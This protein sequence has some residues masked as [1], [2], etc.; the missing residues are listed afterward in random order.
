MGIKMKDDYEVRAIYKTSDN[1]YILDANKTGDS[2][3]LQFKA[4]DITEVKGTNGVVYT[5]VLDKN[6]VGDIGVQGDIGFGVG[7]S[8]IRPQGMDD[9]DG[10]WLKIHDNYGNYKFGHSIMVCVPAFYYRWGHVDSPRFDKYGANALDVIPF[11]AYASV[12]AA[13][14]D[15]FALHRAFYDDGIIQPC[16]FVDKYQCSNKEGVAHSVKFGDPL[17]GSTANNPQSALNG[18]PSNAMFGTI[19]AAKTRGEDFFPK[20]IFIDKALAILSMAQAQAVSSVD[21][22]AWYDPAGVTNY[23]K[24]CNNNAL[25]DVNDLTVLYEGTGYFTAG[26]T[27][28]GTPFAKT[29]HNGQKNGV[30]D[31]N[32][33]MWEVALGL[34]QLASNFY[35]LKPEARAADLTAGI[36]LET[37]AWGVLGLAK[38]YDVL[39]ESFGEMSGVNRS[40]AIGSST[41]VFSGALVGLEWQAS[42]AGIPQLGGGVGSNIFGN[43]RFYDNRIEHLSPITGGNWGFGAN[44]GVWAVDLINSR[45]LAY[46]S[47]GFRSALYPVS[48]SD[49]EA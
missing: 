28:S 17:S 16:F 39:G 10:N 7:V 21:N 48:R 34:T 3:N 4:D 18:S 25:R 13:N 6:M 31:L 41:Q 49:S 2:Y 44:A 38:N 26:K 19:Q 46:H 8:R 9:L 14:A 24:G 20:T 43:D 23:P 33:N 30:A 5:A 12:A 11:K 37:D 36:T 22:C 45:S 35:I 42:C 40:F 1:M 15:G 47:I 27:G 32:G 29:T